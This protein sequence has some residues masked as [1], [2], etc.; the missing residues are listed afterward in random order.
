MKAWWSA[1]Y[2]LKDLGLRKREKS[3]GQVLE[4]EREID[5]ESERINV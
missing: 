2:Y 3:G 5:D 4:A 1:Y